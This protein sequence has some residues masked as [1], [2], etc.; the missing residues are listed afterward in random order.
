MVQLVGAV[1][2]LV[3]LGVPWLFSVFGVINAGDNKKLSILEGVFQVS[4]NMHAKL[5]CYHVLKLCIV[6]YK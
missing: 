3:L 2:T 1:A 6:N 5:G 4:E